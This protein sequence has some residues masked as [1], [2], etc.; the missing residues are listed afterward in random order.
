MVLIVYKYKVKM[1][2][3]DQIYNYIE[4]YKMQ[5]INLVNSITMSI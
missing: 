4:G 2:Y 5:T 3:I 1:V